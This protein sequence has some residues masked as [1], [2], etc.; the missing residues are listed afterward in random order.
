MAGKPSQLTKVS[1]E[2]QMKI[3]LTLSVIPKG[4]VNMKKIFINR[5]RQLRSGWRISIVL[6]FFLIIGLLL[7]L[8]T[9]LVFK[10]NKPVRDLFDLL[11][12][13][14]SMI[15]ATYFVLRIIDRKK[16]AEIGMTFRQENLPDF[17]FGLIIGAFS[18]IVIFL[19]FLFSGNLSVTG[20]GGFNA[21]PKALIW[22]F[23]F[24]I[25]G[26]A[27]E[28]FSRGYCMT[29]LWQTGKLWVPVVV[30]SLLFSLLHGLN[31]NFNTL[32]LIN[33]FLSGLVFAYMFLKTGSLWMPVGYHIA[34][35]FFEGAV[36]GFPVSGKVVE[37]IFQVK[38]LREN[39]MTGGL[40][41][42]EGGLVVTVML[43]LSFLVLQSYLGNR[44]SAIFSNPIIIIEP[45]GETSGNIN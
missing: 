7:A 35:N 1:Y 8:L 5:N 36:L 39:L 44:R 6:V 22:L 19:Q 32:A 12:T 10:E 2:T 34:W 23:I 31:P 26:F 15:V 3:V 16:M 24:L 9:Y 21:L 28:I 37:G 4:A 38:I 30:S 20:F 27:E 41:G 42:P 43:L 14:I 11:I 40:F 33:L 25:A 45:A 17:G 13:S 29:A 18:L